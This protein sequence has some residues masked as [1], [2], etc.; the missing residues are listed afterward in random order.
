M[1][2]HTSESQDDFV[3]IV[4]GTTTFRMVFES[5][6]LANDFIS[7]F[8]GSIAGGLFAHRVPILRKHQVQSRKE[9]PKSYW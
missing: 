8:P 5:E 4:D 7:Q 2:N 1:D 9:E 6:D 3:W